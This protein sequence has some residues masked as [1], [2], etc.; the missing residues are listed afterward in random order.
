M[1]NTKICKAEGC[2]KP[3]RV[4]GYC[5]KHYQ[6]LYHHGRLTPEREQQEPGRI[7]RASGCG[8]LANGAFGYCYAHYAQIRNH[9]RLTPELEVAK[10]KPQLL[11]C[12]ADGCDRLAEAAGYC[13]K[14]YQQIRRY[15]RVTPDR[16][17]AR[18]KP[19]T[20]LDFS[21]SMEE[22]KYP[23]K[24]CLF[25]GKTLPVEKFNSKRINYCDAVCRSKK[26]YYENQKSLL[27]KKRRKYSENDEYRQRC[28][29]YE[30]EKRKDKNNALP[31]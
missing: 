27:E 17:R 8:R 20:S 30:R 7:C 23:I 29:R 18:K 3:A 25:C 15:G 6:Q 1:D 24:K 16:E 11:P 21:E 28:L 4:K 5:H 19:T 13:R 9:G 26:Y 22:D 31:E 2:T 14:H 10:K 12:S